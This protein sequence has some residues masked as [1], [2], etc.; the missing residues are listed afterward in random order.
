MRELKNFYN[1]ENIEQWGPI[2]RKLLYPSFWFAPMS[3]AVK[4]KWDIYWAEMIGVMSKNKGVF[5]WNKSELEE[6]GTRAI[7]NWL[8]PTKKRKNL[9][10]E[11]WLLIGKLNEVS[12]DLQKLHLAAEFK[13]VKKLALGWV[14]LYYKFWSLSDVYEVANYAS[15]LY[16]QRQIFNFVPKNELA[17]VLEILLAPEDLSFNQL[18]KK[19]LLK[20]RLNAGSKEILGKCLNTYARK[21]YWLNNSYFSSVSLKPLY[22]YSQIKNIGANTARTELKNIS[23]YS[24]KLKLKKDSICKTWGLTLEQRKLAKVLAHSIWMQDHRKG[25]AWQSSDIITQFSSFLAK[26]TGLSLNEILNYSADEW[27]NAFKTGKK[28]SS[29]NLKNRKQ[30]LVFYSRPH[31]YKFI[32]RAKAERIKEHFLSLKHKVSSN[33][34]LSG[35][36]VS[37]AKKPIKG[38]AR[39]LVSARDFSK[40]KKGEILITAMTSPDYIHAMRLA[41]A[42]VT[43]VGG[44][45]SHA[46]VVSRELGI[47]CVVGTKIATHVFKDGD[48]VE[49]DANKGIVR[50]IKSK[51]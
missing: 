51:N 2:D 24:K 36:V 16:L 15:T 13:I 42:I 1:L 32:Y 48:L 10:R 14:N 45:M 40:M 8:L 31:I 3:G 22:F 43:D 25:I 6:N 23:E 20:I 39:I 27:I 4:S 34:A 5:Y 30:L 49:V 11:Y 37:K 17:A 26:E 19:E 41:K 44:L 35:L 46:A 7:E 50:K 47:P 28:V 9:E 12:Q 29:A 33:Q 18:A 38:K 21:W